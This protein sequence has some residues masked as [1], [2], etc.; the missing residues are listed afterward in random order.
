MAALT[1]SATS[2]R[3]AVRIS[4]SPPRG[5]EGTDMVDEWGR[6]SFPASDAPQSWRRPP[7]GS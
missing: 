7:S 6:E 2:S 3:D 5:G 1:T 4:S